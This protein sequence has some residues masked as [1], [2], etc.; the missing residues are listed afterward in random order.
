VPVRKLALDRPIL[1]ANILCRGPNRWPLKIMTPRVT[2]RDIARRANVHVSTV[3]LALRD[4]PRLP[5]ET[6][7]RVQAMAR[8]MGYVHDP[9]LDAL[10]A[11]RDSARRRNRPPVLG[12]VTSWAMPL[13]EIPHHRFYWRGARRRAEELG[14]RLEHFSL[15]TPGMTD[16]R[17]GKILA[18]RGITGVVLSSFET[19]SAE[20]SF[21]WNQFA[22]VRIEMQPVLPALSTTAV[23]HV[24]AIVEAVRQAVALGYRRPGFM[25]GHDWSELVEDHWK[26][27]FLWA[28]HEWL[29]PD[30]RLPVFLFHADWKHFPRSYHFR[31]WYTDNR[32]D[33]L[34]GPQFHIEARLGDLNL[35]VPGSV[36]V[37]DPFL[38]MADPFYAGVLH[39]FDE[40]GARAIDSLVVAVTRNAR[41]IPN[42]LV[43]SYVA[44]YWHPGPSC[45]P[46]RARVAR[47]RIHSTI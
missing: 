5:G 15:A 41:G 40:V 17:L 32:P 33:V 30:D 11:Y 10:L 1:V 6:R 31:S 22:G 47:R 43:R 13:D 14:F 23:D 2:L 7:V 20:V 26:M 27:G 38:E 19:G 18:A 12:Y 46:A 24:R 36:A 4:S 37:I 8:E 29:P 9:V 16:V 45:P 42:D 21:D 44:G 34:I 3:S 25:L 39:N 35:S 28:Q